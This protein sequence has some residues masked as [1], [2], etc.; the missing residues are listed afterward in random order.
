MKKALIV[1]ACIAIAVIAI[2]FFSNQ[3]DRSLPQGI[4]ADRVLVE[5]RARKLTL[6]REGRLL[7]A[8]QVSL[9]KQPVGKKTEEGDG[10]TP[11]GVY[12]IDRRKMKSTFHRALHIS[13]PNRGDL[14]QAK[15]RGI[16]PGG[17]IMIHGLFNGL[18]FLGKLHLVDDWTAGCIAVTNP[19]IEEIWR[20][21]P[22]G[23]KVDIV[24]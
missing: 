3:E 7:K 8:Y 13:Y 19:Q 11:E 23:T 12:S 6:Y 15:A 22:D 20:T 21:V 14:A 17:D 18:G 4:M 2:G 24:P 16:S 1:I 10:R 5:K 9:G